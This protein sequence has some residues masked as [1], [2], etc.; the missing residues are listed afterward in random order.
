[1]CI[2]KKLSTYVFALL[3]IIILSLCFIS[4]YAGM[5][6]RISNGKYL[7]FSAETDE[8]LL[9]AYQ[10]FP[11]PQ[12]GPYVFNHDGNRSA[13]YI[14]GNA[15]SP[16]SISRIEV[17]DSVKVTVDN[18]SKTT[19]VVE[20]NNSYPRSDL[21][22]ASPDRYLAVSDL[23]GNFDAM[24]TL[25]T[26]NGVMNEALEWT[27]GSSHL[28][29][30]GDMVDRGKNVL[31]LLWLIYKLETKAKLVGGNVHYILGNHER[32]LLDGR[33][34]SAAKKYLG[35]LRATGMLPSDLWSENAELGAWIRSKPVILKMGDTLFVHGGISPRVLDHNLSL[36][37][38]DT[39]A[40][41]NFVI[42]DTV[43]RNIE[44]SILHG[45]DGLLFYR[46][47]A[48]DMSADEL[49]A[50]VSVEH[51]DKVLAAFKVNRIAIGH[52]LVSHIGHDYDGKIIRVDVAHSEGTS[53]ALLMEDATFWVVNHQG[54]KSPLNPIE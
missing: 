4:W 31:P 45:A 50:K 14:S 24:V 21:D 46:N 29:L 47:L 30:I 34:K 42:G 41:H 48:K 15:N 54:Q 5:G 51:I 35:T 43:Q 10:N 26:A 39:E 1:M 20:L 22:I 40:Q 9:L 2:L 23:E 32:Y 33:V 19:F 38:I 44:D 53:E 16:A 25:L 28:I 11:V 27:Y 49:G 52:T 6:I 3:S 17:K 7:G 37:A 13:V 36:Q 18:Q 8:W 12:D